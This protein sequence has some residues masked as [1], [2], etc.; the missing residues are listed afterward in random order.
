MSGIRVVHLAVP[1]TLKR[2]NNSTGKIQLAGGKNRLRNAETMPRAFKSWTKNSRCA[3]GRRGGFVTRA[4]VV[5]MCSRSKGR[6]NG[7]KQPPWFSRTSCVNSAAPTYSH[8]ERADEFDELRRRAR[9]RVTR[10]R[11]RIERNPVISFFFFPPPFFRG[12]RGTPSTSL[13]STS[14][15]SLCASNGQV[16]I[17]RNHYSSLS[18]F[19]LRSSN[20]AASFSFWPP[21]FHFCIFGSPFA[22]RSLLFVVFF[23]FSFFR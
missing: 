16:M 13:R 18:L 9:A 4:R 12:S 19:F 5:A 14:T 8:G 20:P 6:W 23:F 22:R 15:S 11:L 2:M 3:R 10:P 7:R 21:L 1:S 17:P